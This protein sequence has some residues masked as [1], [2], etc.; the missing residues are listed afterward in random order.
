MEMVVHS[1]DLSFSTRNFKVV[2]NWTYLLF[3]EFFGQG[4]ME[5]AQGFDISFLCDR[6]T[7]K[8]PKTQPGFINFVVMPLFKS[9]SKVL[10]QMSPLVENC[11]KTVTHWSTHEETED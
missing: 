4:D 11:G 8:I 7:V 1:G 2:Q 5:Q 9:L 10:P 6:K 3:D